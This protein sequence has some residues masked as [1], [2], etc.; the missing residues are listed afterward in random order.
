MK[1]SYIHHNNLSIST[2]YAPS[3]IFFHQAV[4][5]HS[6]LEIA[7]LDMPLDHTADMYDDDLYR[8]R[9][10]AVFIA[11]YILRMRHEHM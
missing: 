9:C 10:N 11:Q 5:P 1:P 3:R 8:S 7:I 2:R 6:V 4:S